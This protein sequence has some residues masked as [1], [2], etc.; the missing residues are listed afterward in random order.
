MLKKRFTSLFLALAMVLGL[1][2]QALAAESALLA[3]DAPNIWEVCHSESGDVFLKNTLTEE[4]I[5]AS[6]R[7]DDAGNL[8]PVDLVEYAAELNA[9]VKHNAEQCMQ[10]SNMDSGIVPLATA[11]ARW[12]DE[13]TVTE[14]YGDEIELTPGFPNYLE[15][16]FEYSIS[17]SESY[18]VSF[19]LT[20]AVKEIIQAGASF[21]LAKTVGRSGTLQSKPYLSQIP[22]DQYGYLVF[23]P[24]YKVSKGNLIEKWIES[25]T[26]EYLRE[27]SSPVK[28]LTPIQLASGLLA[29]NIDLRYREKK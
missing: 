20:A 9:S 12:Y 25:E 19:S 6:Y 29:G 27:K 4:R 24:R 23:I 17:V 3:G 18:Q 13:D 7:Y 15:T 22:D 10:I 2:G 21:T 5:V 26:G 16:S 11:Y 14:E 28:V 8:Q 1:S